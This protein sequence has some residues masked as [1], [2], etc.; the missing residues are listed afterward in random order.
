MPCGTENTNG[1]FS[2]IIQDFLNT[3]YFGRMNTGPQLDRVS[4]MTNPFMAKAPQFWTKSD[5]H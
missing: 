5:T 4:N 1:K 2:H 3:L